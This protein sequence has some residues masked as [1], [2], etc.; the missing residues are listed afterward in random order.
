MINIVTFNVDGI[1]PL[2]MNNIGSMEEEGKSST[3]TKKIDPEADAAKR[4]YVTANGNLYIPSIAFLNSLWEGAA[5]QK[6]GKDSARSRI[7]GAVFVVDQ[8]SI[9]IH[10]E[11]GDPFKNTEW[12][13][14][15]RAV[16]IKSTKGRIMRHRPLVRDWACLVSLEV[17][18][19]FI[20]IEENIIPLF[21]IAG[22]KIG[23]MDYRP[24]KRGPFG[25]YNVSLHSIAE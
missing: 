3:R 24:A 2:L 4:L 6:I 1:T 19:D 11:T 8:E 5:Y 15:S 10:P 23:V 22:R 21:N 18:S 14:D 16:V 13:I 17:D 20:D 12:E 7:Q 25:R 9:L